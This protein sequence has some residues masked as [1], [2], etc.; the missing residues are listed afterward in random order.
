MPANRVASG[1]KGKGRMERI[2][3]NAHSDWGKV[4]DLTAKTVVYNNGILY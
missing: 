4:T 1:D 3:W 2:H